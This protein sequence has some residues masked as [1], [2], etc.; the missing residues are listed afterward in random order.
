LY[1]LLKD[2]YELFL[3]VRNPQRIRFQYQQRPNIHLLEGKLIDLPKYKDQIQQADYIV[4]VATL[5]GG[6]WAFKNNVGMSRFLFD[7]AANAE[8]IIYFSTASIL[9]NDNNYIPQARTCGTTYVRSKYLCSVTLPKLKNYEKIITL[10]PTWV[11]GGDGEN[12]P[13]S[14]ASSGLKRFADNIWWLR[15][16]YLDYSFHFIHCADIA[17]I[18]K[19]L[20]EHPTTE[21]KYVLGNELYSM[22]RF[23]T[24]TAKAADKKVLFQIKIPNWFIKALI[25]LA[26][27]VI[28]KWD[29]Y[30][31]NRRHF[32]FKTINA[33][34]FGLDTEYDTVKGLLKDIK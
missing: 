27:K 14:H 18:V 17:Q 11:Y 33:R 26:G 10:F 12:Y 2:D 6:P 25:K 34:T 24:E 19:Y 22:K 20:L 23:I 15:F 30:C 13:L 16:F 1:D 7:H 28:S 32:S 3:L 9:G 29:S 8:K 4:H 31:I 5:W 21:I